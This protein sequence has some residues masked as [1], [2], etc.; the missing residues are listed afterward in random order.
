MASATRHTGQVI[1]ATSFSVRI[2]VRS[3]GL[4]AE[5]GPGIERSS[6]L[7]APFLGLELELELAGGVVVPDVG[8]EEA[9]LGECAAEGLRDV[10]RHLGIAVA[11]AADEFDVKRLGGGI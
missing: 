7:L 5:M 8:V 6:P 11:P 9:S 3:P 2:G 4:A 10:F 1:A